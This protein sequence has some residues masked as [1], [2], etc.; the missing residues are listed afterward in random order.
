MRVG[1]GFDAHPLVPGRKLILGGVEV[2]FE[3]G[4]E[5]HSDADALCH[6]IADALLGAASLGD[7][8]RYFPSSDPKYKGADS[9]VF[10]REVTRLLREQGWKIGNVDATILAQR[11]RLAPF[12][13]QMRA[14]IAAALSIAAE[15]VSIKSKSTDKLGFVGREEGIAVEAVALIE[16]SR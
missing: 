13:E 6:A 12:S 11:P 16:E 14:N 5:G 1:T 4:L 3:K 2:P 9:R 7:M 8:G 10:L 15:Q